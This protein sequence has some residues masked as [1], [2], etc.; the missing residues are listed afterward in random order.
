METATFNVPFPSLDSERPQE[1]ESH[2]E[3][4]FPASKVADS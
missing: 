4:E 1:V 2:L 3:L